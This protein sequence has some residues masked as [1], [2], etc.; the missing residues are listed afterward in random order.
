[1]VDI[2]KHISYWRDG[3]MEDLLV[4]RDLI[5]RGRIRHGLFFAHLALEKIL[6][7]NVCRATKDLAPPIHNLIRLSERAGLTL[8]QEHTDILADVNEFNIEGRYPELL[9]PRPSMDEAET[10]MK[11]IEEVFKWL[12]RELER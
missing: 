4:A 10:Y 6:K 7:A 11:R 12:S 2:A 9:L 3:A 5:D 1:M 8:S